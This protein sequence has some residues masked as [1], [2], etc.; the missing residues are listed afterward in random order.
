M[1]ERERAEDAPRQNL[2]DKLKTDPLYFVESKENFLRFGETFLKI[3]DRETDKIIPWKCNNSQHMLLNAFFHS[4]AEQRPVRLVVLKG[5]QQGC[6]TG[7]GAIGFTHMMCH[8]GANLLIATETK[9]DSGKNIYDM[10]RRYKNHFPIELPVTHE[11]SGQLIQFGEQMND[12]Y[13]A[14]TGERRVVSRTIKFI[15]LSEAAKFENLNRFMD[16]ML[17]TVPMHVMDTSIFVESTAEEYGDMFHE[18][19]EAA[20]IGTREGYGWQQLF[21]PWWVHEEYGEDHSFNQFKSE[22]EKK[23]FAKSL[24]NSPDDMFGDEVS[25]LNLKPINIPIRPGEIREVGV[26]LENLKWRRAKISEKSFSLTDFYRQYPSTPDEAFRSAMLSPLDQRSLAWYTENRVHY[27]EKKPDGTP[28]PKAGELRKPAKI[29]EFFEK[30][31]V[32]NTFDFL[33]VQHAIV[34]LW[35]LVRQYGEYI[36]GVDMAQGLET[37]DFSCAVVISRLPFRVV[38]VLRG[39][40]G[41][42]LDPNEFGRQLF[43]LGQYYNNAMICPENNADGGALVRDLVNWRYPNLVS[44]ELITGNSAGNR[45]GWNNNGQTHKR[46][47]AKLQE[48]IREKRIDIKDEMIIEEMKHM[49]YRP[50]RGGGIQAAKKGQKRRPGSSA[51]GYYDDTVFATGGAL[52]LDSVLEAPKTDKQIE[53]ELRV[54][55]LE[56]RVRQQKTQQFDENDWLSMC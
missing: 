12:A 53:N 54:R 45:Y 24:H 28:H 11:V 49:V 39:L 21:I 30:D 20:K 8:I 34:I 18:L 27:P 10:Y 40:D 5:R 36:I 33:E 46:M 47:V 19:W 37:G 42:R 38:A 51:V 55:Q 22:A 43:A 9:Q 4:R 3:K 17:E 48:V 35:E 7:V 32:S 56:N 6:S 2:I 1:A 14:V 25:L 50:G 13:I 26:T 15:H 23:E 44:E 31:E 52:L 29:G 41:R 16:D